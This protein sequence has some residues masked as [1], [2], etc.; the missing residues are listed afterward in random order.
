M[1]IN[2]KGSKNTDTD[3]NP[4]AFVAWIGGFIAG[5]YIG[6]NEIWSGLLS[7]GIVAGL[8]YYIWMR[9]ALTQGGTESGTT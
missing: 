8:I 7:S 3:L 1:S 4:A 5:F 2:A 9:I 6:G